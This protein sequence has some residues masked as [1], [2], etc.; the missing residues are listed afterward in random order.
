MLNSGAT[1]GVT[2]LAAADDIQ[3]QRLR[4][5]EPQAPSIPSSE[6][7]FKLGDG[8]SEPASATI[9][10]PVTAGLL[11]GQT[12]DLHLIDKKGNDTLPLFPISEMRKRKMVIDYENDSVCFKDHPSK[13]HKLPTTK[14]GLLLLPLTE[15]AVDR[16]SED[17]HHAFSSTCSSTH[18]PPSSSSSSG[19]NPE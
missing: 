7:V 8:H 5:G 2:S 4:R 16:F 3:E 19:H 12:L 15:E 1:C 14:K 18:S 6:K 11:K 9:H 13:W 17:I 10:Q